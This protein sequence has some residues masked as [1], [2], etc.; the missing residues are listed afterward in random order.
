MPCA[1]LSSVKIPKINCLWLVRRDNMDKWICTLSLLEISL[2]KFYHESKWCD[3]NFFHHQSEPENSLKSL[4]CIWKRS[5]FCPAICF[6]SNNPVIIK[7]V[8]LH[9]LL[10]SCLE[11]NEQHNT[12]WSAACDFECRFRQSCDKYFSSCPHRHFLY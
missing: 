4:N 11:L 6:C 2:I 5:W 1:V 8:L 10:N 12:F 3:T 7:N 9:F